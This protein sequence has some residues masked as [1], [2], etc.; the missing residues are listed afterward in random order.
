MER[1][2]PHKARQVWQRVT[3]PAD[4]SL[5]N[6]G[7][8]DL[9]RT[10]AET[11]A[12]YQALAWALKGKQRELAQGLISRQQETVCCLRGMARIAR[13]PGDGVRIP[14]PPALPRGKLG[15]MCYHRAKEALTE[16]T[17]WTIDPE[18]GPVFRTLAQ[19]EEEN[20]V[21][22]TILLGQ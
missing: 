12:W 5:E 13:S 1:I 19:R 17:A 2:D 9:L 21:S 6:K 15:P 4:L 10:A 7:L 16:Y 14:G 20:C 11:A 3:A 18:F 22:L 8:A